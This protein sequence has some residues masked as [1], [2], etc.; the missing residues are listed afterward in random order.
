MTP[1]RRKDG[2]IRTDA[3]ALNALRADA[4]AELRSMR[5]VMGASDFMSAVVEV[6]NEEY[7]GAH[8]RVGRR[9]DAPK[10]SRLVGVGVGRRR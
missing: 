2:A 5:D 1:L 8:V 7:Q 4:I 9:R 10:K 3:C 6:L